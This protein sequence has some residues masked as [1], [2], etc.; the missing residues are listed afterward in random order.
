MSNGVRQ[1]V[2][3]RRH[4]AGSSTASS[5]AAG[6][7][8]AT[9]G[10]MPGRWSSTTS[11]QAPRWCGAVHGPPS[12]GSWRR[13]RCA[14][15]TA[16]QSSRR[17]GVALSRRDRYLLERYGITHRDYERILAAQG[18][19]CGICRRKPPKPTKKRPNPPHFHVDHNHKTGVL[20]GIL[21]KRC[22]ERLL[23]AALDRAD[24]LRAAADYLDNAESAPWGHVPEGMERPAARSNADRW[25]NAPAWM[26]PAGKER[27]M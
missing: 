7:S 21:C 26:K 17:C 2:G 16:T 20:R 13:W 10:R 3:P 6:A 9:T 14:A 5:S 27:E 15:P 18:G 8:T 19:G 23:T 4:V 12:S 24:I 25:K 22:N 1:H 11:S